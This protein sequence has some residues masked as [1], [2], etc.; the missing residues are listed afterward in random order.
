MRVDP[1]QLNEDGAAIHD[2]HHEI[3]DYEMHLV[4]HFPVYIQSLKAVAGGDDPVAFFDQNALSEKGYKVLV[5]HDH[6]ELAGP[7]L[8]GNADI[9][10]IRGVRGG[11]QLGIEIRTE[12]G[13]NARMT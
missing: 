9:G 8:I 6:D 5:I 7:I 13:H 12:S 2:G 3:Q 10:A 11:R 4:V 1:S